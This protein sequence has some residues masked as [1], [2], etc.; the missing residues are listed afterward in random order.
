M[1]KASFIAFG[2]A[3]FLSFLPKILNTFLIDLEEEGMEGEV[4]GLKLES[5]LPSDEVSEVFK[6]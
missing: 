1:V 6:T 5:G 2:L 4:G 3:S